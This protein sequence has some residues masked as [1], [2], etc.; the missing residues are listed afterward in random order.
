M[1]HLPDGEYSW[2][3]HGVDH[4]SKLH[5]AYLLVHKSALDVAVVLEKYIFPIMGIPSI[6]QS[7]NGRKFINAVIKEV[8]RSWPGQV[9][10]ISGRPRHPQSQGLVEQA[11]Y[12][13]ERMLSAKIVEHKAQFP[14][15]SDWLLHI[16]CKCML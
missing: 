1:R 9:Q 11:H 2:I 15:W 8:I 10:L 6:L 4:W 14:P 7:D 16:V 13:L 5:F 12:T 3:L